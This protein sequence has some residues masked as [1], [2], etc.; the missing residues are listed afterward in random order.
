M[1]THEPVWVITR[2]SS[3][4]IIKW[5]GRCNQPAFQPN[6]LLFLKITGSL[7]NFRFNIS[8]WLPPTDR[9]CF[10]HL[11]ISQ[12]H[13][14]TLIHTLKTV[15]CHEIQEGLRAEGGLPPDCAWKNY[16]QPLFVTSKNNT[17]P[18]HN[19]LATSSPELHLFRISWE[20]SWLT[21]YLNYF[22]VA[23]TKHHGQGN[24]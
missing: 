3:Y 23:L 6:E 5:T 18:L 8:N 10:I 1:D 13:T 17:F 9:L 11:K 12:I 20:H 19:S 16:F 14:Y 22:L 4:G 21:H 7:P 15:A 24:L 2:K